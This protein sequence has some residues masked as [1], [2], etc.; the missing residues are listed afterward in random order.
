MN[1]FATGPLLT[2]IHSTEFIMS[3]HFK[4][5]KYLLPY[6]ILQ[7]KRKWEAL[8]YSAPESV[9]QYQLERIKKVIKHCR[10]HVPYYRDL[11]QENDIHPQDIH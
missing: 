4:V 7:F 10:Q 9:A 11:F 8:Q 3:L 1:R 2:T 5:S 6:R